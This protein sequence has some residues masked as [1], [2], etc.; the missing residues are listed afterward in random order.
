MAERE[1]S[2]IFVAIA[3][4]REERFEFVFA[5]FPERVAVFA[6]VSMT[7]PE[8]VEISVFILVKLPE[9]FAVAFCSTI[10]MRPEREFT[11]PERAFCARESVK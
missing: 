10:L 2:P 9:R 4:E 7:R 3:H 6:S 1:L 11:V 5:R 8:S